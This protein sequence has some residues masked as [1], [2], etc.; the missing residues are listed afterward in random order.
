MEDALSSLLHGVRPAGALFDQSSV[1][2]PWTLRFPDWTPLTLLTMF[3]GG[4]WVTPEGGS[5][6]RLG[7]QDVAVLRGP[8]TVAD[9]PETAPMTV[10]HNAEVC[11]TPEGGEGLAMCGNAGDLGSTV[12]LTCTFQVKGTVSRRVLDAL[13]RVALVPAGDGR[14][15][16]MDM[17]VTEIGRDKPGRQAVLDRLLDLLLVSSLREWFDRPD[18]QAPSWYAAHSDQLIG[19]ALRA[20]HE[21]PARPWTVEGLARVSG[22]S[23]ATFAQRFTE[24]VGRPPMT[25][26][27]E[28]RICQAADLLA[29]TDDTVD[30]IARRVGYSNAYALSVAFKRTLGI[31]PSQHRV[32]AR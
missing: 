17:I 19:R 8:Y 13:P 16:T 20:I 9:R 27:T 7:T 25:Y 10:L 28:W 21:D 29:S 14:C 3:S 22:A 24:L 5:P 32:S 6:V 31:R 11:A 12:L 1:P 23:R 30:A 15:A 4:A 26:L 18:S 2:A